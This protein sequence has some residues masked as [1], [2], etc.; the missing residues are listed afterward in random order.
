MWGFMNASWRNGWPGLILVAA[1]F[2]IAHLVDR[3]GHIARWWD[4]PLALLLGAMLGK[5]ISILANRTILPL[6][7]AKLELEYLRWDWKRGREAYLPT[8]LHDLR[9][10]KS[11]RGTDT[12]SGLRRN[13]LHLRWARGERIGSA[14]VAHDIERV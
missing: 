4:I 3:H 13:H 11:A 9:F 2:Y 10:V 6:D 7:S 14:S 12:R 1:M 8:H 5:L